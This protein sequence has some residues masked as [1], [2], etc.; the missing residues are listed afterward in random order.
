MILNIADEQFEEA[1]RRRNEPILTKEE[2]MLDLFEKVCKKYEQDPKY[3]LANNKNRHRDF[4][5][6]RQV[7]MFLFKRKLKYSLFTYGDFFE[8]DH[9]TVIHSI[10][11]VTN[12]LQTDPEF[13]ERTSEIFEV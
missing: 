6:L 8:K 10:K 3:I 5:E 9:A 2:K 7:S 4:V 11:Q 13:Q 12:L 1:T